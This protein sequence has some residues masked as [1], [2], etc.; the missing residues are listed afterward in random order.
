MGAT[1]AISQPDNYPFPIGHRMTAAEFDLLPPGPPYPEL[2][3][4]HLKMSPSPEYKHQDISIS[5]ASRMYLYVEDHNLGRILEAP[6]D[7][8]F[9]ESDV[10]QPDIIF[11]SKARMHELLADGKRIIGAPDLVVEI[12]SSNKKSDLGARSVN[13]S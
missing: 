10:F 4:N 11:I 7:V 3:N 2:I 9:D 8:H 5:L 1:T 6:M 13:G 12:L